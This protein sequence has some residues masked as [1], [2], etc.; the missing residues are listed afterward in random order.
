ME[1]VRVPTIVTGLIQSP[2]PLTLPVESVNAESVSVMESEHEAGAARH[3]PHTPAAV[4]VTATGA[5]EAFP[6]HPTTA[7]IPASAS[8][9]FISAKG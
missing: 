3:P 7:T 6:A 2:V 8:N 1:L 5:V 4:T 9:R